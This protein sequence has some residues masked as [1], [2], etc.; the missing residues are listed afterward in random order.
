MPENQALILSVYKL[1]M[2]TFLVALMHFASEW[3]YFGTTNPTSP[4][5]VAPFVIACKFCA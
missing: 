2:A 4:G 1:T 5:L 3:L